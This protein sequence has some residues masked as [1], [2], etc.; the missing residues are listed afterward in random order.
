[1]VGMCTANSCAGPI[2]LYLCSCHHFQT[3]ICLFQ[4]AWCSAQSF[5]RQYESVMQ[6]PQYPALSKQLLHRLG[7]KSA[8]TIAIKRLGNE[9]TMGISSGRR[10]RVCCLLCHQGSSSMSEDHFT[11]ITHYLHCMACQAIIK[12]NRPKVSGSWAWATKPWTG[13]EKCNTFVYHYLRQL[14]RYSFILVHASA[15]F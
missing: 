4:C 1:M 11:C 3:L 6:Q 10:P 7:S 8:G 14:L 2:T 12:R 9:A 15:D 13:K 5:C